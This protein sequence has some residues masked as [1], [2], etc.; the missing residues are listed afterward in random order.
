[1]LLWPLEW[2]WSARRRTCGFLFVANR[3]IPRDS[4]LSANLECSPVHLHDVT[5][6]HYVCNADRMWRLS[7]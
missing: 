2:R 5:G 1:V 4:V 3:G 6:F 7:C